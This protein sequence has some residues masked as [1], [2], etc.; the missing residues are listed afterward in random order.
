MTTTPAIAARHL[1]IKQRFTLG[2]N[3]YEIRESD[4]MRTEGA[5][6]AMAQQKRFKL[7]EE[8]IFFADEAR[9]QRVFSFKARNIMDLKSVADIFD[10]NQQVLGSFRKDF[11]A[12]FIRSTWFVQQNGQAELRGEE[13]S[14]A[15]A[16]LRRVMD[17]AW[18]PYHFDFVSADG[19]LGFSVVKGWG[20]RDKYLVS[21]YD[22]SLDNRVVG[23]MAVALDSLQNR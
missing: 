16:I 21:I 1:L 19:R 6:I 11:G 23:A 8:V 15:V 3:R 10:A 22:A 4:D 14:L 9:T 13:R 5:L 18:V 12:S 7:K 20:I 2:V 17:I